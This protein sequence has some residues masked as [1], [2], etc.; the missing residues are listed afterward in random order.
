MRELNKHE[1]HHVDG[2]WL[3]FAL[4]AARLAWGLYRHH[5]LANTATWAARGAGIVSAT[6][7]GMSALD[8]VTS[9]NR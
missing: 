1:L 7:Q 3:G 2:A 4:A 6:Y 5:K 8:E 9:K